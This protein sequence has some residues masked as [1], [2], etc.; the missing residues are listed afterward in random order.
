[1]GTE[2]SDAPGLLLRGNQP[3]IQIA[4]GTSATPVSTNL[5]IICGR[6]L[7]QESSAFVFTLEVATSTNYRIQIKNCGA[8]PILS[9]DGDVVMSIRQGGCRTGDQMFCNDDLV[10]NS[11]DVSPSNNVCSG[12]LNTGVPLQAGKT[13]SLIISTLGN[14]RAIP[15]LYPN[16]TLVIGEGYVSDSGVT[17]YASY[18]SIEAI[19]I[20]IVAPTVFVF[21]LGVI[22][23]IIG[24]SCV[25]KHPRELGGDKDALMKV[26]APPC[27]C[28]C[29]RNPLERIRSV[30]LTSILFALVIFVTSWTVIWSLAAYPLALAVLIMAS[31][32]LADVGKADNVSLIAS[33]ITFKNFDPMRIALLVCGILLIINALVALVQAIIILLVGCWPGS[34]YFYA[35]T[36]FGTFGGYGMLSSI[37]GFA[38]G[39]L[40]ITLTHDVSA[41]DQAIRSFGESS[42][43]VGDD[44]GRPKMTTDLEKA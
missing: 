17:T 24:A 14:R 2:C 21:L 38:L 37:A 1:M 22:A 19:L 30:A 6:T 7:L 8:R 15:I 18:V 32:I 5:T 31:I 27:V 35:C 42:R 36:A 26:Q 4:L 23:I 9:T 40:A 16:T 11:I 44:A 25:A 41:V 39:G 43:L 12:T 3:E 34:A 10:L 33:T 28:C 29:P 13:Y 20:G